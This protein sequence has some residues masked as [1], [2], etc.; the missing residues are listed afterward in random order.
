MI[1]FSFGGWVAAEMIASNPSQFRHSVLVAPGG[2][3]APDGELMDV[4]QVPAQKL[5][6]SQCRK[7]GG[8]ARVRQ[9]LW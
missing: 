4:F 7:C 8:D 5:Y 2:I 6:Q 9:A 1:G 3:K